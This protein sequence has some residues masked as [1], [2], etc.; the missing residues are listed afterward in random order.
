MATSELV[1]SVAE[2]WRFPVKSMTGEGLDAAELDERG[3]LGDRAYA[4]IDL[5]TG[6]VVSAKSVR[7]FPDLLR[8]RAE[9][10]EPPVSG[11]EPPPVRIT[12]P[13]GTSVVSDAP[14][15]DGKLSS[16]F[17]RPVTLAR[18]APAD[19]TID[20]YHPDVEGVDPAGHRDTIVEQKLGSAFFAEV[21]LASPVPVGAFFDL[22]PLTVLTTST[23]E[24]LSEFQPKSRFDRRRFRMNVIVDTEKPGFVEND[25]I[26]HGLTIGDEVRANVALPDP[27]CVMTTLAQDELP[28]DIE[29]IRT[30]TRYNR[31]AVAGAG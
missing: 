5:D 15:A 26:G 16:Y 3:V 12:L 22:F 21:G 19:F 8:C 2:I 24:R 23:L 6:K 25:W 11:T 28:R 30:L 18:T 9:F 4:L 13:D 27:R 29:I 10:I 31:L 1:G 17:R 7:R 20:Q 14:D